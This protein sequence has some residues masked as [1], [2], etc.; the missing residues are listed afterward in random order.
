M[1]QTIDWA[2]FAGTSV[3]APLLAGLVNNTGSFL[4]SSRAELQAIYAKLGGPIGYVG[5]SGGGCINEMQIDGLY[6]VGSGWNPCTGVGV[7]FAL[8]K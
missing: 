5:F 6:Q 4:P 1:G 3:G 2:E 7:P 8:K